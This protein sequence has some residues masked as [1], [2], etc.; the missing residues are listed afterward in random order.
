MRSGYTV[1]APGASVGEHVTSS[2]EEVII[3]LEGSAEVLH[4]EAGSIRAE[5]ES[6]VYMPP[7]TRH[8]VKNAGEGPLRYVYVVAML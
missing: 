4:G 5:A 2:R 1:L 8:D 3:I 6:V 7:E